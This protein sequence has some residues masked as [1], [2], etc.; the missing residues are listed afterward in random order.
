MSTYVQVTRMA[1]LLHQEDTD[2]S[3]NPTLKLPFAS[4]QLSL[5]VL[6]TVA[7]K[8]AVLMRAFKWPISIGEGENAHINTTALPPGIIALILRVDEGGKFVSE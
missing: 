1:Y 5:C 8:A 7:E 2:F 3:K 6:A 4:R